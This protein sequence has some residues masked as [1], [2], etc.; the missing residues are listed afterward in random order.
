MQFIV[1]N[2]DRLI[3]AAW[4]AGYTS[5]PRYVPYSLWS[6]SPL[7]LID[8]PEYDVIRNISMFD[9]VKCHVRHGMADDNV[10][11]Y[12]SRLLKTLIADIVLEQVPGKGHWWTGVLAEG[13]I[14]EFVE[15][16]LLEN[17]ISQPRSFTLL[18]WG[19]PIQKGGLII[20]QLEEAYVLPASMDIVRDNS[21]TVKI[22]THGVRNW[23][24]LRPELY[25]DKLL[26]LNGRKEG[27]FVEYVNR[28]RDH[29]IYD[30]R[31][32]TAILESTGPISI[33]N[34]DPATFPSFHDFE[35]RI[36]HS[37]YLYYS[38]DSEIADTESDIPTEH[39]SIILNSTRNPNQMGIWL[40]QDGSRAIATL[41]AHTPEQ[42]SRL[43]RLL[44]W[45]TGTGVPGRF[46]MDDHRKS[47]KITYSSDVDFTV[48]L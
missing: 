43:I 23:T 31:D 44:P 19:R 42:M 1:R 32:L 34:K 46:W 27:S 14:K 40:E 8:R 18:S 39:N 11:I 15:A 10:P 33:I 25:R 17:R 7:S 38:L 48:Q 9:G 47:N 29:T 20:T 41:T 37:L 35:L 45:R 4:A 28:N 21:H 22:T 6:S 36:A 16:R 30:R 3:G 26:E 2:S 24:C 5:I 13:K 12:H